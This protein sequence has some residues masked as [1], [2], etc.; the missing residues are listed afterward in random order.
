MLLA[1]CNGKEHLR[2][3]AVSLRQH[4]FLVLWEVA[5]VLFC[6]DTFADEEHFYLNFICLYTAPHWYSN[7][8]CP[9]ICQS[10]HQSDPLQYR[11][12]C[13]VTGLIKSVILLFKIIIQRCIG[14]ISQINKFFINERLQLHVSWWCVK[15]FVILLACSSNC[16]IT[17]ASTQA[18]LCAGVSYRQDSE[19]KRGVFGSL[20]LRSIP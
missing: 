20:W 6:Y 10:V 12:C 2:H 17:T 7:S 13:S 14:L 3:R 15:W 4:G 19:C 1:N 9:S 18:S 8:F 16:C 5:A 11:S